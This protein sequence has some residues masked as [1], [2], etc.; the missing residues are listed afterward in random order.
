MQKYIGLHWHTLSLNIKK[1]VGDTLR[2]ETPNYTVQFMFYYAY[3]VGTK[4]LI[5]YWKSEGI[6]HLN[7][8]RNKVVVFKTK[9]HSKIK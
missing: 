5:S 2:A 3:T 9:M 4:S 7:L 8:E 6:S 1:C